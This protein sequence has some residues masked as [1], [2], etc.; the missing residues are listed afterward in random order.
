MKVTEKEQKK[1]MQEIKRNL[2]CSKEQRKKF[3]ASFSNNM[4]E[5]LNDNSDAD[6]AQ[7]QKDL[8]TPE[9][10]AN[11]FLENASASNVKKQ[12]SFVKWII[13]GVAVV[14]SVYIIAIIVVLI[15]A[16]KQNSGYDVITTSESMVYYDESVEEKIINSSNSEE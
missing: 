13:V 3:L 16:H 12:M 1:Y 7:L 15:D 8:G 6:F 4:D 2:V 5:Y 9:E 14:L 10:I 11:A